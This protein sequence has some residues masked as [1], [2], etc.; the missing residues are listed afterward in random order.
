MAPNTTLSFAMLGRTA[1]SASQAIHRSQPMA[2]PP[3]PPPPT[4]EAV[5]LPPG[6]PG[7]RDGRQSHRTSPERRRGA[8][9]PWPY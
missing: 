3:T 8:H 1:S 4:A 7:H 6:G 5:P 9:I 2:I